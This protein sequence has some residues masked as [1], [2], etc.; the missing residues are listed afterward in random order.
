LQ[1]YDVIAKNGI[2]QWSFGSIRRESTEQ[3]PEEDSERQRKTELPQH[4]HS[5]KSQI[6]SSSSFPG[7]SMV[8]ITITIVNSIIIIIIILPSFLLSLVRVLK[9]PFI[10]GA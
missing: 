4:G 3:D 7:T 2:F 6:I 1:Q 5:G 8:P 10:H 9:L